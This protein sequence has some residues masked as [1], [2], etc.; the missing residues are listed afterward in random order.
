MTDEQLI[1]LLRLGDWGG[2]DDDTMKEAA[3]RIEA[4]VKE[5][6]SGSFYKEADIDALMAERDRAKAN[7]TKAVAALREMLD[8]DRCECPECSACRAVL[9]EIGGE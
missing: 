9:A 8:R 2:A 7:L 3:A 5:M 1:R 6:A 4:L